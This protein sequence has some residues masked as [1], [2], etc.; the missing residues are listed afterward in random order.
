[1]YAAPALIEILPVG[2][3]LSIFAAAALV[4]VAVFPT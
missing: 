1:V 2:T 4:Q 3:V